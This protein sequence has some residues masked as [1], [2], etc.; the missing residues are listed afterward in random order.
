MSRLTLV[1]ILALSAPLS[2]QDAPIELPVEPEAQATPAE[3]TPAPTAPATPAAPPAPVEPATSAA[4]DAG[5]PGAA[6]PAGGVT[7]PGVETADPTASDENAADAEQTDT[8]AGSDLVKTNPDGAVSLEDDRRI[9]ELVRS[10]QRNIDLKRWKFAVEDVK[11]LVVLRPFEAD[12]QLAL[13]LLFHKAGN[14]DEARR[15]YQDYLD[16]AGNTAIGHLLIAESYAAANANGGDRTKVLAHMRAA[17]ESGLNLMRAI[18][19][20]ESMKPYQKDTEVIKLALK[21]ERYEIDF[22]SIVDP[23]TRRFQR[24]EEIKEEVEVSA[25]TRWTPAKQEQVVEEARRLLA[26]IERA[27]AQDD[28]DRAMK[29]YTDLLKIT[30]HVNRMSVPIFRAEF[31][32]IIARKEEIESRIQEIRLKYFYGQA[33]LK[34]DDMRGAFRNE[35]FAQVEALYAEVREIASAMNDIN[36][37]F[38]E[39]SVKVMEV[40]DEWLRKAKIR[41]EFNAKPLEIQGIVSDDK[42][43]FVIINDRLLKVGESLEDLRVVKIEPH[44]VLML[45]KGECVPLFFRYY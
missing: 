42:A 37:E 4:P 14:N 36:E 41:A 20:F 32:Q 33:Q 38:R 12:F 45:F 17:A 43:S 10:A 29:A 34:I 19:N 24:A 22:S 18:E 39:V 27:L 2:A 15:K 28:E 21:L 3:P 35:D 40:A 5:A 44:R 26:A 6:P 7:P 31:R 11:Q 13:G 23:M 1:A 9:K 8:A 30:P 16:L 25:T